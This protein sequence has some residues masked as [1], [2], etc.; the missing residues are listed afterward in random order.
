MQ[1]WRNPQL[2]QCAALRSGGGW[3]LKGRGAETA[4]MV[5]SESIGIVCSLFLALFDP[6]QYLRTNAP[7]VWVTFCH[8]N[9]LK[10]L[11]GLAKG[12]GGRGADR[13]ECGRGAARGEC[14]ENVESF[15]SR[16]RSA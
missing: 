9:I 12:R 15:C 4:G 8:E 5:A 16:G 10:K 2:E 13:G 1:K 14:G 3:L 6:E 11:A 7:S